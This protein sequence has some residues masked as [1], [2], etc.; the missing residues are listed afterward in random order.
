MFLPGFAIDCMEQNEQGVFIQAH[1]TSATALCPL[2][3]QASSHVHSSYWRHPRDQPISDQVVYLKLRV[4]RFRCRNATCPQ[5]VFVERLPDLLPVH[6]QRTQR[7]TQTLRDVGFALGGEPGKRLLRRLRMQTSQRTLL[8]IVRQQ[9]DTCIIV[10]CVLGVDDWAIRKGCSYGTILV[11]LERHRPIDLLPGRDAE[12]LA[13]W[14][15]NHPGIE[16]IARDRSTEYIRGATEGAPSATQVADRWHLLHNLRQMLERCLTRRR[17]ELQLLPLLPLDPSLA[18][19]S[20]TQ[21]RAGPFQP[22]APQRE[23]SAAS[24][25]RWS[26]VYQEV[27][28]LRS[29]GHNILQI[30]R[31]LQL[32]RKTV[33]KYFYLEQFPKR[34]KHRARPSILDP[35]L[36]Y[37]LTRREEGC[38]NGMQLWREICEKG[39]SGTY[40]QVIRWLRQQRLAA[41]AVLAPANAKATDTAIAPSVAPAKWVDLPSN[42]VLSWLFMQNKETQSATDATLLHSLRQHPV[43]EQIYEL[44][45]QFKTMVQQRQASALDPWLEACAS[46]QVSDLQTFAAGLTQ[47]YAAVRAALELPWSNGQ[48]EGHI[49]RLKLLKRQMYG[50]AKLDLL[51]LRLL[52]PV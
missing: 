30:A 6:A 3:E 23:A 49:N 7:L 36:P 17:S 25:A 12:T 16:I 44:T 52:H 33:R 39:Y 14:L 42:R 27:Q 34:A 28:R 15:Y 24:H 46:S 38:T 31:L 1:T 47:D 22:S 37:L 50:R 4:R 29:A 9:Q 10:P 8:R 18:S 40:G 26:A 32:D 2:C 21:L 43:V 5:R 11:D 19:S 45:Q 20:Q 41:S 35:Y 48:T 51:R 13:H